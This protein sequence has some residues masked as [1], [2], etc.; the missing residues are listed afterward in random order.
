MS[1]EREQF[2]WVVVAAFNEAERLPTTLREL[3]AAHHEVVV[4]D[5]GSSDGTARA[6]LQYPVWVLSHPINCGQGAALKTGIDFALSKGADAIVTFDA[7][8]QHDAAE[9]QKLL[10]PV[11]T[12]QADVALG[13]RFLGRSIGIP[14]TRKLVLRGG[15]LFTRAFSRIRVTD[16]HNGFRALSAEAARRIHLTQ[17]RMA[18]ASEL[19]DQIRVQGL[20]HCEVPVTI[21][22]TAASLQKG[23]S[24]WG[25]VRIVG[26]LLLGRLMR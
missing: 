9:I 7:D 21:R 12:G 11:L 14:W 4:V 5:D 18:H 16:A 22:Y 13:S 3:C 8:G 20:R 24:S 1:S 19:L 25:A 26:E 10:E 2:I 15:V 23:Q 6:A 17:P